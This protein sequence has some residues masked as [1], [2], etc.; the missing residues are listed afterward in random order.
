L[1]DIVLIKFES[2]T[3]NKMPIL[4][5]VEVEYFM[6]IIEIFN[7]GFRFLSFNMENKVKSL[8]SIKHF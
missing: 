1:F 2:K 3:N 4:F 8:D 7:Y 6:F 5:E